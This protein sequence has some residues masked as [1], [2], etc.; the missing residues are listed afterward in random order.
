MFGRLLKPAVKPG[1][2]A[3]SWILGPAFLA[4]AQPVSYSAATD[5]LRDFVEAALSN[6]PELAVTL[7]EHRAAL[8]R[9]PQV[10]SLPDPTLQ[11]TQ[12][13]RR[14][15]TRVGPQ[16]HSVAISQQL[17]WFGKLD[18]ES[19]SQFK[20]AVALYETHRQMQR[21]LVQS[22]KESYYEV[23]LANRSLRILQ[24]ERVLLDLYAELARVRFESGDGRLHSAVKVQTE[25]TL[26][27]D[28]E[29][30]LRRGKE[31][32]R[33]RLSELIGRRP[34]QIV[35]DLGQTEVTS[36]EETPADLAAIAFREGPLFRSLEAKIEGGEK[37]VE[38]ARKLSWPNL[39][40]GAAFINVGERGDLPGIFSPPDSN[41][42]NAY[43]FSVGI[44][45]PIWKR[46][47]RA[48]VLEATEQLIS[49]RSRYREQQN[50]L[51]HELERLLVEIATIEERSRLLE[52]VLLPQSRQA[53]RGAEEAYRAGQGEVLAL[54]DG[55]RSQFAIRLM[56]AEQRAEYLKLLARLENLLG[57]SFPRS[58]GAS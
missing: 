46:K 25:I 32:A 14:V 58:R 12:F 31:L 13:V 53:V 19:Q 38:A 27:L 54:L 21:E 11:F 4:L 49:Q 48:A 20:Q 15:E 43:S 1:I 23:A 26:L 50:R 35:F 24:E 2:W 18:L 39:T 45:L 3:F 17:P 51:S 22:V 28:R 5:Q 44:T 55:E 57:V 8:Q 42:K 33:I 7:A 9:V 52:T 6:H 30:A 47:Y 41:G 40:L 56:L 36:L 29:V 34:D 37:R 16:L 10:A